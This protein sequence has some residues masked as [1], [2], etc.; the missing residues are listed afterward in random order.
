ME[1]TKRG[2]TIQK[3]TEGLTPISIAIP[4]NGRQTNQYAKTDRDFRA[5]VCRQV[6]RPIAL[7]AKLIDQVCQENRLVT[8][9]TF[10]IA[11]SRS[12]AG[13]LHLLKASRQVGVF[14]QVITY[15]QSLMPTFGCLIH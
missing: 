15:S 8:L 11:L 2:T 14:D 1:Q 7:S 13:H 12:P 9:V 3:T 4:K 10:G 5:S 6:D